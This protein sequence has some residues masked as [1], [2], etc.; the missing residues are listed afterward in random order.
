MDNYNNQSNLNSIS[1]KW[2]GFRNLVLIDKVKECE[3][4]I[5]FYFKAKD[6]GK[7]VKHIAGQFLPFKIKTDLPKYKNVIRT[8]SLSNYPNEYIYRIS[9][10]KVPNGL[11]S[12]Y[13]HDKLTIGDEIEA[14][15]PTG[16]FTLNKETSNKPLVFLSGGIGITPLISM[17]YDN[18]SYSNKIYFIQAVQNS[19]LHPFKDNIDNISKKNSIENVVFYS[20]PLETDILNK[21][22]SF[23]GFITKDWIESN[24][25]L[26]ADFYFC[27][28]PPFMKGINKALKNLGVPTNSIHFEFFGDPIDLE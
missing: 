18:S 13:L 6:G 16:I 19:L 20:K 1:H 8:Y 2:P 28:P 23:Q 15:I 7:L 9:V 3:D 5:S 14:M 12:N 10:K 24:L 26:D 17:L 25:P 4:I 11:I 22:Y 27:G 21:D